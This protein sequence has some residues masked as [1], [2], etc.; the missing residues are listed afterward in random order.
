MT[1]VLNFKARQSTKLLVDLM[2]FILPMALLTEPPVI[3]LPVTTITFI[4]VVTKQW[5]TAALV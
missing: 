3:L 4:S 5:V 1:L 2:V